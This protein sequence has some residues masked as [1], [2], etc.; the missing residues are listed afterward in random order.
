[1]HQQINRNAVGILL[2]KRGRFF[3]SSYSLVSEGRDELAVLAAVFVFSAEQRHGRVAPL[4]G[5]QSLHGHE[6]SVAL[7]TRVTPGR[8]PLLQLALRHHGPRCSHQGRR[9]PSDGARSRFQC[10][11][12]NNIAACRSRGNGGR[13]RHCRRGSLGA[14]GFGRVFPLEVAIGQGL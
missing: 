2:K 6:D 7:G 4:V 1:M 12:G 11:C 8:Q 13:T 10:L 9:P 14:V 5:P 3:D